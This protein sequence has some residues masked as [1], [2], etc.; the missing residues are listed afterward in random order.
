MTSSAGDHLDWTDGH[1]RCSFRVED[2]FGGN[3]SLDLF[4]FIIL[5]IIGK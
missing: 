3:L 1:I 5:E 2:K 4:I